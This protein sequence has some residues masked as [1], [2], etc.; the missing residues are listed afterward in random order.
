M[1]VLGHEGSMY[2]LSAS[3]REKISAGIVTPK[4]LLG[5]FT[6]PVGCKTRRESVS[7]RDGTGVV[8]VL[9]VGPDNLYSPGL[10][11]LSAAA[12]PKPGLE[13]ACRGR[14]FK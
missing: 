13:R 11:Q 10:F 4:E 8:R 2:N 12:T 7:S 14:K 3:G 5:A 6:K 1:G 9:V